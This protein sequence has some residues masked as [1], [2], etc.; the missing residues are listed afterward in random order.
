MQEELLKKLRYKQGR[1]LVL[2]APEGYKLGIEDNEEPNGTYDFV[3]LFVNNAAEVEE[4]APKAIAHLNDEAVFW[5]TYPKQSSKVK[6]DI[7][8]DILWKL[9]DEKTDY[10]LVSNVA[11]DDKWSALRLRHKSKVKMKS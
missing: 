2:Q 3:Q 9:M 1:A 11:V 10:R 6:T 5:I 4:L 8:R 7:N